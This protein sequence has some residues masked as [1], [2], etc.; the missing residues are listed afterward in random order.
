MQ[1]IGKAW[2]ERL[3]INDPNSKRWRDDLAGHIKVQEIYE[4]WKLMYGEED[5]MI[6]AFHHQWLYG[7]SFVA[8]AIKLTLLGKIYFS[9]RDRDNIFLSEYWKEG[10]SFEEKGHI[11]LEDPHSLI[12]WLDTYLANMF[13]H[14]LSQYSQGGITHFTLLNAEHEVQ[15]PWRY[16]DSFLHGDNN[17]GVLFVDFTNL[18]EKKPKYC[19][20]NINSHKS[21]VFPEMEPVGAANYLEEYYPAKEKEHN[22]DINALFEKRLEGYS[23]LSV[24]EVIQ[25]FPETKSKFKKTKKKKAVA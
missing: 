7:R 2:A 3:E 14:E 13:D 22:K 19:F 11:N 20:M 10:Y 9:K 15:Y 16:Y 8:T 1:N 4:R 5:T 12:N 24:E 17:D 6:V 21:K 23:V 25:M 18:V